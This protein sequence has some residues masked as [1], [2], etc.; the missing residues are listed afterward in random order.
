MTLDDIFKRVRKRQRYLFARI[1]VILLLIFSIYISVYTSK[2]VDIKVYLFTFIMF[3]APLCIEYLWGMSVYGKI[4]NISRIFGF[5]VSVIGLVIIVVLS[6]AFLLPETKV[7]YTE[8]AIISHIHIYHNVD[9]SAYFLLYLTGVSWFFVLLD[10]S[11]SFNKED[12]AGFELEENV[13]EVLKLKVEE[14]KLGNKEDLKQE[15]DGES[16][17]NTYK[18]RQ[19][20]KIRKEWSKQF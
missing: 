14:Q 17:S 1:W 5:F 13:D 7:K 18:N 6:L 16:Q 3:F 19:K 9:I 2:D 12:I 10:L 11:F 8:D 4:T 20:H 15:K